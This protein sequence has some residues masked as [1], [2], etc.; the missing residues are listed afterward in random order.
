VKPALLEPLLWNIDA[1]GEEEA[2]DSKDGR[3]RRLVRA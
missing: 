2:P 3:G 1:D